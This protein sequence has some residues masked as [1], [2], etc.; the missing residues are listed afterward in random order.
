M[1]SLK[2]TSLGS[3]S[4]A[5]ARRICSWMAGSCMWVITSTGIGGLASCRSLTIS[6]APWSG[7]GMSTSAA[8]MPPLGHPLA[9]LGH[10]A[11]LGHHLE[12]G[13]LVHDV[14]GSL[15]ERAVILHKQD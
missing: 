8:S 4:A 1:I 5:P 2:V 15:A 14:G 6:G 11:G 13:L 7:R 10:R 3:T 12:V 9:S